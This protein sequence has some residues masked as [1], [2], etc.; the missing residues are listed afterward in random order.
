MNATPG[1]LHSKAAP[2]IGWVLTVLVAALLAMSGVM[3]LVQPAGMD[4][5]FEE[6]GWSVK[7]ATT[8]GIIEL[9]C[10]VVYLF[11]RTSVTGAILVTGYMGGAIATHLRLEQAVVTQCLVPIVA[12]L[13]IFL[14]EPRLH[15]LMP[16]RN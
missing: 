12:W 14:R 9:G 1:F 15:A 7:L 11:P 16:W 2:I 6:I 4:K 8:L 3:K 5:G 13:G 10:V